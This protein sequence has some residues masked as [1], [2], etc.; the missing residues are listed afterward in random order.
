M[1]MNKHAS[2]AI[3]GAPD[4]TRGLWVAPWDPDE[5]Y[6][7]AAKWGNAFSPVWSY[8]CD[9]WEPTG[10]QVG[11]WTHCPKAALAA[12]LESALVASGDDPGAAWVAVGDAVE[13]AADDGRCGYCGGEHR[14]ADCEA[15]RDTIRNYPNV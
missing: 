4:G 6:A 2:D 5:V 1:T 8:G 14:I 9:G 15:R 11:D 10:Q 13:F 3:K 12:E 7:V